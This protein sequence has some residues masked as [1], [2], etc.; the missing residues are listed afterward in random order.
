MIDRFPEQRRRP[1]AR[2]IAT[3]HFPNLAWRIVPLLLAAALACAALAATARGDDEASATEP[4]PVLVAQPAR[5]VTRWPVTWP[6]FSS[7]GHEADLEATV[8][9]SARVGRD[10]RVR[11]TRIVSSVPPLDDAAL[12][13]ARRYEFEAARDSAGTEVESWVLIPLQWNST[14]PPGAHGADPIPARRYS[15]LE[16]SFES[17]VETL[18]PYEISA[19][20][21]QTLELHQAI[22][23]DA[24]LLEVIPT[25][26]A[27]AIQAFLRGD[28]LARSPVPAKRDGR[29][30]AWAEAAHLAPWWPL[31]YR[32]LAAVAIA[33]RNYDTAAACANVI[34]AG[35]AN[36]EE[37]L[38]IL[39]RTG[40][41]R[42][43]SAPKK[44]KK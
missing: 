35:R 29:K 19:P 38:A 24:N 33:E 36:D 28:T 43:A 1:H 14:I 9:V 32:R 42:R 21:A 41:L 23:R 15:D 11:E 44:S 7:S 3:P 26:G 8:I 5:L 37:A 20:N 4:F 13:A 6:E 27:D 40:Q 34:L 2:A 39:K 18:R 25:P 17:D 16:R 22:M 12:Q 31:P 30:A 10:G